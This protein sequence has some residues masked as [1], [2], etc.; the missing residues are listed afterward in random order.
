MFCYVLK[1][2]KIHTRNPNHN[3][4]KKKP[5]TFT[6]LVNHNFNTLIFTLFT[7]ESSI[8]AQYGSSRNFVQS[9]P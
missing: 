5:T 8:E 3:L 6:V 4:K 1:K 2:K 9:V 7:Y